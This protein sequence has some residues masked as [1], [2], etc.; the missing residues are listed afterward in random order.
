M[1][2]SIPLL[3]QYLEDGIA[4]EKDIQTLKTLLKI[5]VDSGGMSYELYESVM[6]HVAKLEERQQ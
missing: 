6:K 3:L 5:K 1:N 2:D 4:T